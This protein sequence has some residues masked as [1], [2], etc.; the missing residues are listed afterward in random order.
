MSARRAPLRAAD[1]PRERDQDRGD[2]LGTPVPPL[3]P[4]GEYDAVGAGWRHA[5]MLGG[6]PRLI[7]EWDVQVNDPDAELGVRSVRVLAYYPVKLVAGNRIRAARSSRYARDWMRVT[8]RRIQRQDRISP[9]V[10][11]GVLCRVKVVT[12]KADH[13]QQK[14][15]DCALYS[16]VDFLLERKAGGAPT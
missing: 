9:D 4:E 6:V 7:V 1:A 16:K 8:G 5:R 15:P 10:F 13:R 3:L 2:V 14:L 11:V 12:V